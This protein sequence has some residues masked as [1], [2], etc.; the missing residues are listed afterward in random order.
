M[1]IINNFI[2]CNSCKTALEYELSDIHTEID[3]NAK[4][5]SDGRIFKNY[6][7]ISKRFVQCP[8]CH[9]IIYI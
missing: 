3:E 5:E 4:D 1:R 9:S 2:Q 7:N 6:F 8:N